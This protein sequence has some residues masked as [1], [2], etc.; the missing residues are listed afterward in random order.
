MERYVC[1]FRGRRD[2]YQV[3][4]ALAERQL[5]DEFITDAYA[6]PWLRTAASAMPFRWREK[7]HFRTAPGVPD[8]RVKCLWGTTAVEHA[9]HR[10]G[11]APSV[12]F[13]KLDSHFS[14]AAARR[15]ARHRAHLFLYSPYAWEAFVARYKHTPHKVMFQYHPHPD[16]ERRILA[17]DFRKYPFVSDS[18]REEAGERLNDR[19]KRRNSEAW[20]HADLIFCASTFTQQSLL[21]VGA[22]H[23]ACAVVP[24]GID[25]PEANNEPYTPESFRVLFVG[26]GGQRKGLHH[27][28]QAWR[29]ADLREDSRLTLVC[30]TI[31]AGI[32]RM[33]AE[34]PRVELLRGLS[35]SA[36]AERFRTSTLFAMPSLV[37]GFGQVFL[38]A[39]AHG[40]PVLGTANTCLPD[41]GSE[42]DGIYLVKPGEIDELVAKLEY[43]AARLAGDSSVRMRT[44]RLAKRFSW[45]E[46]RTALTAALKLSA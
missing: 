9:R 37:E 30:R 18:F 38:E 22:P 12:T 43:T 31:D 13:A 14:L 5:L 20:R 46:F 40:C 33:A 7:L 3:P 32:E 36:L 26:T 29:Q 11:C 25:L 15:A 21:E 27:L 41:L 24:Y 39:M 8:D 44:Q 19:L 42:A 4:L 35:A 1:A 16:I 10:I 45:L 2:S 34:T 17:D 6:F 28:L 23:F